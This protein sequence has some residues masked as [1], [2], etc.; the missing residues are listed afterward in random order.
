MKTSLET[1]LKVLV[2]AFLLLATS[3][4][5]FTK[6][7]SPDLQ[8]SSGDS[9]YW[10]VEASPNP[11]PVGGSTTFEYHTKG[12]GDEVNLVIT[13]ILEQEVINITVTS[14]HSIAWDGRDKHGRACS[15]GVYFFSLSSGTYT[16]P[17]KIL[18]IK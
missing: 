18:L 6:P 16:G 12:I 2:L 11:M 1:S 10:L 5:L 3:C 15:S 4:T 9:E 13:N 17:Q 7:D 8:N 14:S